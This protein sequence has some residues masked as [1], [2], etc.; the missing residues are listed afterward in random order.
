VGSGDSRREDKGK[1]REME[2]SKSERAKGKEA[3]PNYPPVAGSTN[4]DFAWGTAKTPSSSP[5]S[6]MPMS[7]TNHSISRIKT[8][9]EKAKERESKTPKETVLPVDRIAET[10][11]LGL[12]GISAVTAS[13]PAPP[14]NASDAPP[15]PKRM[16]RTKKKRVPDSEVTSTDDVPNVVFPLIQ[17]ANGPQVPEDQK[18]KRKSSAPWDI[19]GNSVAPSPDV[20][21]LPVEKVKTTGTTPTELAVSVDQITSN[22]VHPVQ[23][24]SESPAQPKMELPMVQHTPSLSTDMGALLGN[25]LGT[26]DH[27][28]GGWMNGDVLNGDGVNDYFAKNMFGTSSKPVE[29]NGFSLQFG[30]GASDAFGAEPPVNAANG[31]YQNPSLDSFFGQKPTSL[32]DSKP[33]A[34]SFSQPNGLSDSKLRSSPDPNLQQLPD[35]NPAE[36]DHVQLFDGVDPDAPYNV[37]PRP[38][39]ETSEPVTLSAP[40]DDFAP[41]STRKKKKKGSAQAGSLN[42]NTVSVSADPSALLSS[43]AHISANDEVSPLN[44]P[45][46][47]VALEESQPK[48]QPVNFGDDNLLEELA[49]AEQPP[50]VD[51]TPG[52]GAAEGEDGEKAENDFG[53]ATSKKKKKKRGA[54]K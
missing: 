24:L 34:F 5:Q 28:I 8:P 53:V 13:P 23:P 40:V 14:E 44:M 19:L 6:N 16:P 4:L 49:L 1:A 22:G 18:E 47:D 27:A 10:S 48:Q 32:F 2:R 36:N 33:N 51:A 11:D 17:S 52:L 41:V 21:D 50:G 29:T 12:V 39:W 9:L 3:H 37:S 15:A 43:A 7:S 38:S 46:A 31:T 35:A 26:E 45:S 20:A 54:N 30:F 25:G 42:D